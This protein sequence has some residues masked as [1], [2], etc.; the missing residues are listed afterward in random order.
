MNKS[1]SHNEFKQLEE[2]VVFSNQYIT[3]RND[4]VRFPNGEI[5]EYAV[6]ES[7]NFC[8]T[9]CFTKNKKLV[10]VKQYRY[11][12]LRSSW[13][14]SSG[15]IDT[16]ETPKEAAIREV[17]EETGY[18]VININP[19]LDYY[20][21]GNNC[22]IGSLFFAEVENSD[23]SFDTDEIEQVKEFSIVEIDELIKKGAIIHGTTLLAYYY[24]KN[25][26]LLK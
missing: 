3:L 17:M 13:E 14:M 20:P 21:I 4:L 11:P 9:L 22:S 5:G 25:M 7:N 10:M 23:S 1:K 19:L 16:G 8:G 18:Q 12:W 24:A 26:R 2:R 15:F 6:V